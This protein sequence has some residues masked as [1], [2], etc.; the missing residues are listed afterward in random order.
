MRPALPPT[1]LRYLVLVLLLGGLPQL[2]QAAE[3]GDNLIPYTIVLLVAAFVGLLG[4]AV[5]IVWLID[6]V[7][8]L[9]TRKKQSH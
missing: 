5:V 2:A 9:F 6:C 7:T 3:V 1:R 8:K 4:L